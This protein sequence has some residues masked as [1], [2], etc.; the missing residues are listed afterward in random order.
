MAESDRAGLPPSNTCVHAPHTYNI[1]M[2]VCT[3]THTHTRTCKRAH[4]HMACEKPVTEGKTGNL[5]LLSR[6]RTCMLGVMA[7]LACELNYI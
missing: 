2:R 1:Y 4:T 7:T 6:D 5:L 3:N